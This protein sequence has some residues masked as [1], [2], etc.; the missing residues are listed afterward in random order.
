MT[1]T[2]ALTETAPEDLPR[3]SVAD[4][5]ESLDARTFTDALERVDAGV[6][7]C[8]RSSTSTEYGRSRPGLSTPPTQRW[9][10]R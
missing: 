10:T 4:V 6:A 5:H 7:G 1:G 2:D 3:W 9:P 8:R